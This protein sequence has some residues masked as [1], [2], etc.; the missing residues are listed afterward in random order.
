MI[1]VSEHRPLALE[2]M[3]QS[4][5]EPRCEPLHRPRKR[6]MIIGLDE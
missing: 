1:A 2:P 5:R 4:L 6:M 3:I